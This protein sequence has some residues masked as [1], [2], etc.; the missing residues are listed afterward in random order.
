M[1]EN[2]PKVLKNTES[3][4]KEFIRNQAELSFK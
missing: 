2:V 1:T 4:I 3:Q